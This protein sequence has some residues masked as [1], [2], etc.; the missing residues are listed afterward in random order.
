MRLLAALA[1]ALPL[2]A[3]SA[4]P[5]PKATPS[6]SP[7]VTSVSPTPTVAPTTPSPT[8]S[9]TR[10]ARP[11]TIV[12]G[13]DVDLD[14]TTREAIAKGG[15]DA[16]WVGIAPTLRAADLAFLNLECAVSD[17]GTP[18]NK[19]YTFRGDPSAVRGARNAGVDVFSLANNHVLDYGVD[20][21]YD[22]IRHVQAAGIKTTGAGRNLAEAQ[23]PA[24]FEVGGRRVAFLGI[25]AI[26]PAGKWKATATRPGFAYD[27][28][29]QIA[30]QVRAAKRVADIV[31]PYFHWGIEY[32]Y[33]PSAAQKRAARAAIRA[34]ATMVIGGHTHVLQP[35]ETYE[36][37][38]VAWS[39]SNLVFQSRPESVHT[40]LLKV[41]INPDDSV[42]WE[43]EPYLITRGV[44]RPEKGRPVKT[45]RVPAP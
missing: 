25:S 7:S 4:D 23:A 16:P 37:R 29:E 3:C 22:T 45:G 14:R 27:D 33:S 28:D 35:V 36:G 34:G 6:P 13:G 43:T 21:F 38:L 31:I 39:M 42:V 20:A 26:I 11:I 32:T 12:F 41:T 2:V 30:A 5:V 15:V 17:R 10:S 9:P 24:V 1:A 44:P 40:Q 8:P 19:T 18:E